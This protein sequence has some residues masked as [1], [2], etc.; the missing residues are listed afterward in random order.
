M[1]VEGGNFTDGK[2]LC[3]V[4]FFVYTFCRL[5]DFSEKI[6]VTFQ[7]YDN[8]QSGQNGTAELFRNGLFGK[9]SKN[10]GFHGNRC[11]MQIIYGKAIQGCYTLFQK[12]NHLLTGY[13]HF[14]HFMLFFLSKIVFYVCRNKRAIMYSVKLWNSRVAYCYL[15]STKTKSF[16]LQ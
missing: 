5:L 15:R 14:F 13:A 12:Q 9:L 2:F 10:F 6:N 8:I 4:S 16:G 11:K 1:T 7:G 3:H